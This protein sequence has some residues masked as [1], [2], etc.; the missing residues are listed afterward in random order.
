GRRSVRQALGGV[1]RVPAIYAIVAATI[2]LTTG[3]H[4]PVAAM[5]PIGLLSDAALPMMVLVLGMQLER[6]TIPERPG[7]VAAA[8]GLS[9]LAAPMVALGLAWL[10]GVVDPARQAGVVL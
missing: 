6:A 7:V 1:L 4:L 3:V 9:L 8:V 10:L 2:V 5:R